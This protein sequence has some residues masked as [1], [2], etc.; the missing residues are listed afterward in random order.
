MKSTFLKTKLL[1]ASLMMLFSFSE[2]FSQLTITP[3]DG[4]KIIA[5]GTQNYRV[6]RSLFTS[7][8]YYIWKVQ[9][10]TFSNGNNTVVVSGGPGVQSV[11]WNTNCNLAVQGVIEVYFTKQPFIG[12]FPIN[13]RDYG[14][15]QPGITYGVICEDNP[16]PDLLNELKTIKNKIKREVDYCRWNTIPN[17]INQARN[18]QSQLR[19]NNCPSVCR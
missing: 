15:I 8:R 17:L 13:Y 3:L 14:S 1:I 12:N 18:I 6:S 10:G 11:T 2:S 9:H 4:N 5:G 16:C 7:A 19:E